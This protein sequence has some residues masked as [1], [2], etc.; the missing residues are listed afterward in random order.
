[1]SKPLACCAALLL[2]SVGTAHAIE[3]P[4]IQDGLWQRHWTS[5]SDPGAKKSDNVTTI[6]HS[7]EDT[8]KALALA[9]NMKGCTPL[10]ENLV[11][12]KYTAEMQCVIGTT[13][14]T[15]KSTTLFASA[16]VHSESVTTYDPPMGG[17]SKQSDV[18]DEKFV[19]PCPAGM[20]PGDQIADDG[21]IR[22]L[23]K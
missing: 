16:A 13:K 5:V 23:G 18:I 7:R 20:K 10:S 6:C 11:G 3:Y 21:T 15:S 12:G 4:D 14:L 2:F 22:H 1:M 17:M 19:G 8:K 9:R